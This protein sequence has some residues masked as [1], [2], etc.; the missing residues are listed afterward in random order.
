[1]APGFIIYDYKYWMRKQTTLLNASKN[2][3]EKIYLYIIKAV[4][5][6]II[7]YIYNVRRL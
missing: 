2:M 5:I 6:E 7:A 4:I 1:M 3:N